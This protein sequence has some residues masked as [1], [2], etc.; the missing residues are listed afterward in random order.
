MQAMIDKREITKKLRMN[1]D[2]IKEFISLAF[3]LEKAISL[4]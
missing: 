4:L 3:K 1:L 2:K